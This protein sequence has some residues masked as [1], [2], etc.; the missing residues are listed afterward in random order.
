M[1]AI[2]ILILLNSPIQ[3][4][5]QL[6][7][8]QYDKLQIISDLKDQ[9]FFNYEREQ[10][11]DELIRLESDID[12]YVEDLKK[13]REPIKDFE[14]LKSEVSALLSFVNQING[15]SDD[16]SERQFFQAL[17]LLAIDPVRMVGT[18]CV[19]TTF[20]EL[21][22][23]EFRAMFI[24][25]E[26][27]NSD[28]LLSSNIRV[29][30]SVRVTQDTFTQVVNG[31]YIQFCCNRV[32]CLYTSTDNEFLIYPDEILKVFC[33]RLNPQTLKYEK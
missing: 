16:L 25:N 31:L 9:I 5:Y 29:E 28:K 21:I 1:K 8:Y 27:T 10:I 18:E 30:Y 12:D 32:S 26:L 11:E 15:G 13:K 20:Y 4:E 23:G 6:S 17:N 2:L 19:Y 14:I 22:C 7:H 24:C 3:T 33:K